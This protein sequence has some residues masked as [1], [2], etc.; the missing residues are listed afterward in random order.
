[1]NPMPP[2]GKE[3]ELS[4][5]TLKF[6]ERFH[7][8]LIVYLHDCNGCSIESHQNLQPIISPAFFP[9][10]Q[11]EGYGIFFSVNGFD[12][13]EQRLRRDFE[14]LTYVNAFFVDVDFPKEQD[15]RGGIEIG[16]FKNETKQLL[17]DGPLPP[18]AVVETKN[19][20]HVYWILK[21]PVHVSKLDAEKKKLLQKEYGEIEEALIKRF[22]G[23]PQAKDLSR[24][25]R[26]P[27]TLHQKDPGSPFRVR[28]DFWNPEHEYTWDEIREAFAKGTSLV[29]WAEASQDLA[30]S[31]EVRAKIEKIYP[32]IHRPSYRALLDKVDGAKPGERNHALLILVSACRQS[33]WTLEQ[34]TSYFDSYCGLSQHEIYTTI[35][36]AYERA[37]PYDFGYNNPILSKRVTDA[38]R[39]EFKEACAKVIGSSTLSDGGVFLTGKEQK[40]IY[41]RYEYTFAE[42]HP[43]LRAM[44]G[45]TFYEYKDGYY[46][47]LKT[48]SLEAI[49]LREMDQDGLVDYRKKS[50]ISDKLM[51]L[52]SLDRVAFNPEQAEPNENI[53]NVK[54]GLLNIE[55][56]ELTPHTPDY[57]SL[58]QIAVEY[59]P[60][61]PATRFMEFLC[62]I[63]EGDD[64]Q[65]RLL[66][67]LAGYC[68]TRDISFH[69]AFI[70]YGSG[71]NGKGVFSRLL[72]RIVGREFVSA[73]TLRDLS[74]RFG[75]YD[76]YGKKLN[77]ID[78]VSS[79]YFES[80]V[81]KRLISGELTTAK[82]KYKDS[83]QFYPTTKFLFSVNEL[84]RI[85]DQ[86][87]GFYQ[88][89]VI[90]PFRA[91]FAGREDTNL[92]R[93]IARTEM[94]GI[95]NWAIE[96]LKRLRTNGKF[97]TSASNELA[98]QEFRY[99]NSPLVEFLHL[100]YEAINPASH[101][102]AGS[103][104]DLY[105]FYPEYQNFCR[106]AGYKFKSAGSV[107]KE[108][109]FIRNYTDF[110]VEVKGST[111]KGLRKKFIIQHPSHN[112]FT[113]TT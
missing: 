24:I 100:S 1:M 112:G 107:A 77:L 38:E 86:S 15:P 16:R 63:S 104:M 55:T 34:A 108:F 19:G 26:V 66:Q 10:R 36:S 82:V 99:Q 90:I 29:E 91:S 79:G 4:A 13:S 32:K 94:P 48:E 83:L 78:E 33:G 35:R 49:M 62:E 12:Q 56:K 9:E 6:L 58:S 57:V 53:I 11:K 39:S 23:D 21:N 52:R 96:G 27:E 64:S 103:T 3:G 106:T 17:A 110:K 95:L 93:D 73:V 28:L 8:R 101:D 25:L 30:F 71:R 102:F 2:V 67:E 40:K 45:G 51:C 7:G 72:S 22:A 5:R 44:I 109:E 69:K 37:T 84:P 87:P 43:E 74:D 97:T 54:N 111:I 31:D 41:S 88:R 75:V 70:L 92:E 89:F 59:E 76:L 80:D 14:H 46:H 65:A 98:M 105:S 20:L 47:I 85:N 50:G 81:I 42:R 113:P 61:A 18:S 60:N 68:L